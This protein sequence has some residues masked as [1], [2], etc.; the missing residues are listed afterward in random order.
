M[1]L[2]LATAL[3][4]N[5]ASK[6]GY[7]F[8][9]NEAQASK[10]RHF[11]HPDFPH[12]WRFSLSILPGRLFAPASVIYHYRLRTA[13]VRYASSNIRHM[14]ETTSQPP[15]NPAPWILIVK[16]FAYINENPTA[17]VQGQQ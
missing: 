13:L 11:I 10:E 8:R 5:P 9:S 2:N 17:L 4:D 7:A 6:R 15:S 12:S 14:T 16:L 3:E 1:D